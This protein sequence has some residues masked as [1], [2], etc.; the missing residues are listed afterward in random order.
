MPSR[1]NMQGRKTWRRILCG[2][3]GGK[4]RTTH[5]TTHN[6]QHTT[7]NTQ[8]STHNTQHTAHSTQHSTHTQ[9]TTH[10]EL[11]RLDKRVAILRSELHGETQKL[12]SPRWNN[13]D[14]KSKKR[15]YNL[16][17]VGWRGMR[18]GI[19][20]VSHSDIDSVIVMVITHGAELTHLDRRS[21]RAE[22]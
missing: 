6:T 18:A 22:G 19:K 15:K 10:L 2:G 12:L 1:P 8:H 9:H 14:S 7:P 21:P 11:A 17:K 4:V 3:G 5:N 13:N 16:K 20:I